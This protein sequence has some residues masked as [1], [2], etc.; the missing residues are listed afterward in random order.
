MAT[1]QGK[2]SVKRVKTRLGIGLRDDIEDK[3][4]VEHMVVEGEGTCGDQVD[5]LLL[6][7][8]VGEQALFLGNLEQLINADLTTPEGLKGLLD[9]TLRA[10]AGEAEDS[11]ETVAQK[12][13]RLVDMHA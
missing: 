1:S 13:G 6:D 3:R 9:L 2:V 7:D 12:R 10:N 11:G 8:V 5:A 4:V